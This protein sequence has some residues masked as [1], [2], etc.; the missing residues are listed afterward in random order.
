MSSAREGVKRS[1]SQFSWPAALERSVRKKLAL[2]RTKR[3]PLRRVA[4]TSRRDDHLVDV[5]GSSGASAHVL[6]PEWGEV[7]EVGEVVAVAHRLA[8]VM[9]GASRRRSRK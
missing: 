7:A 1:T 9:S 2:N 6:P 4:V 3:W 5:P 8:A